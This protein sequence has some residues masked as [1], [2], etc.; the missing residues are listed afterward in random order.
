MS[1]DIEFPPPVT[2]VAGLD[3][4]VLGSQLLG[5]YRLSATLQRE[6]LQKGLVLEELREILRDIWP[7]T[8]CCVDIRL[9]EQ[10]I[11]HQ[12]DHCGTDRLCQEIRINGRARGHVELTLR[13]T[14]EPAKAH[15][16]RFL[17]EISRH[18]G[19][20]LG[21]REATENLLRRQD[22]FDAL[23]DASPDIIICLKDGQGRWLE[24]NRE[25]LRLFNLLEVDYRGKTDAELAD[26][27]HPFLRD[28]LL[29]C[30]QSDEL[31]WQQAQPSRALERIPLP[32][33]G[34]RL[35]DIIKVPLFNADGSRRNLVVMGRDVSQRQHVEE[36]LEEA[37]HIARLG[38]WEWPLDGD[39]THWSKEVY[40][41]LGMAPACGMDGYQ[42]FISRIHPQDRPRVDQAFRAM[43]E[44]RCESLETIFRI[45]HDNGKE[46]ILQA[47][48]RLKHD[49]Q[50]TPKRIAG[51]LQ[52]ITDQRRMQNQLRT[53]EE[54]L[55]TL[56]NASPD[57][58]CFKDGEGRWLIANRSGLQL[59]QLEGK[60]YQGKTDAELAE[61]AHPLYRDG[62]HACQASDE[63]AWRKGETLRTEEHVS[64][65][66]GGKRVFDVYKVPLFGPDGSRQALVTL[67]RDI[68]L[69][70]AAEERLEYLA[71]HDALTGLPNRLLFH[72]RLEHALKLARREGHSV[73]LMF[74]DLDNFKT[75][76]DSQGHPMGDRALQEV[77]R[78]LQN[79]LREQDTIARLGG[80]EF[81]VI[82]EGLQSPDDAYA[83]AEKLIHTIGRPLHLQGLTTYLT[84]SI[85]ISLYP[86]DGASVTEL[87]RMADSAMYSAKDSGKNT[88]H[89][90]TREMGRRLHERHD[91]G[92]HLRRA[93]ELD[94]LHLLYQPQI[95]VD[96]ESLLG[97]EA[98]L[99]WRHPEKGDIPPG[100]FIPIAEESG[101]IRDIGRWVLE[102]ACRQLAQWNAA[103]Y[104]D[105]RM[106]V[107]LS[108][109]QVGQP[110]LVDIVAT[111]IDETGITPQRLELEIT[112]GSLLRDPEQAAETLKGLKQLGVSIA[113]D[114]FGT[115]Y[116]S[117]SHL[118][119]FPIDR[120]KIDQSFVRDINDDP[121]DAAIARA[122]IGLGKNLRKTVIAE[123]VESGIQRDI[124]LAMGCDEL[125]GYFF[126]RPM[127]PEQI[128]ELLQRQQE[129]AVTEAQ[130]SDP[131]FAHHTP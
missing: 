59:Y 86:E 124:L 128:V 65:P 61:L 84:A 91:L 117:L 15:N 29:K 27:T 105:L 1:R 83:V 22:Y 37:Q 14:G 32:E 63:A 31:A 78:R 77:A 33:G 92:N 19:L 89:F 38:S 62:F 41:L 71:H 44:G 93:L 87:M 36:L 88:I 72:D 116:S 73:A 95:A 82:L 109:V 23:L 110:E 6:P 114:D 48:A 46:Q 81:V 34:D 42:Q 79:A 20:A 17:E 106:A 129:Q 3:Q 125:Q 94:Q 56:I 43:R 115:G 96:G 47:R 21:H 76:N 68:S 4:R 101:L 7:Q 35:F 113:L 120:I 102:H 99:R 53:S 74:L 70:I 57:F 26:H 123:G 126:G 90:Y 80:D 30:M 24:A 118:K 111:I 97:V 2:A 40:H 58:I 66:D 107:N 16:L 98:L 5:L 122:V 28:A 25:D 9:D 55:R 10:H 69:R 51:I 130:A 18:L 54:R 45:L 103:G 64:L 104:G 39:C 12:E 85:G 75:L 49:A 119:R 11:S 100:Q 8:L 127:Q 67:G 131:E 60:D 13:S 50:G 108:C 52:D 121:E 112:E